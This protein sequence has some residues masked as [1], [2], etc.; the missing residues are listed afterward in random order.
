[1][2]SGISVEICVESVASAIAAE[3]G[4]A[5]RVELCSGLVEGGLTPST[6]LIEMTRAAV[7][8][9]VHVMIRPRGGDFCYDDSE[10]EI[11]RRDIAAAKS[12][13]ANGVVFGILKPNGDIDS[14]RTRQLVELARPLEVTF[15]R[16]FDMTADLSRAL[17]ELCAARVNRVLTSG[18]GQTAWEGRATIAKLVAQAQGRIAIMAGSGIKPENALALV[19]QTDVRDVHAGLRSSVAG[20]MLFRNPRISMGAVEG[21]EYE[22]FSVLEE[23]VKRLCDALRDVS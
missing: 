3:R 14:G 4:G 20:P 22:R 13:G 8:L 21:R 7:S 5:V 11:M 15:H 10:F 1:M 19:E 9:G 18:A 16:A 23:N 12:L 6:G 17:E 2:S